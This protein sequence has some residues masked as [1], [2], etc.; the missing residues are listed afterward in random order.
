MS[1]KLA[2]RCKF[3]NPDRCTSSSGRHQS[4]SKMANAVEVIGDKLVRGSSRHLS[5]AHLSYVKPNQEECARKYRA[6]A[7]VP[8]DSPKKDNLL[9]DTN[10]RDGKKDFNRPPLQLLTNNNAQQNF[11]HTGMAIPVLP[12]VHPIQ[13]QQYQQQLQLQQIQQQQLQQMQLQ[14]QN[15]LVQQPVM[16][17]Y[18]QQQLYFQ[19]PI[20]QN[21]QQQ[22]ILNTNLQT[23]YS[24]PQHNGLINNQNTNDS[25]NFL[26]LRDEINELK[27]LICR[28]E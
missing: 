19:Q 1:I 15:F 25:C 23:N 12:H 2:H 24:I 5:D 8:L 14:Q 20:G 16:Q 3:T 11:F 18:Q 26:M 6:L 17:N 7:A 27:Q 21:F 22:H 13:Q 4:I 10:K 28:N 9:Q